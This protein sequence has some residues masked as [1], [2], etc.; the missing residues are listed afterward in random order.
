MG[1]KSEAIDPQTRH[2]VDMTLK[3]GVTCQIYIID[4]DPLKSLPSWGDTN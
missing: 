1:R 4:F 2:T 3:V